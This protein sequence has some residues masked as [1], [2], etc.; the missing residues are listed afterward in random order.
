MERYLIENYGNCH[1]MVEYG[2]SWLKDQGGG[3]VVFPQKKNYYSV[4]NL[5]NENEFKQFETDCANVEIR[6]L[7]ARGGFTAKDKAVFLLYPTKEMFESLENYSGAKSVLVLD[8]NGY[9]SREWKETYNP[10][11]IPGGN[12]KPEEL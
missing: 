10:E 5:R 4:F 7:T 1:K 9:F 11:L 12:E 8:W 3:V 6:L 2:F